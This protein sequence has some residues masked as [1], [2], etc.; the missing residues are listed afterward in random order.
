[1]ARSDLTGFMMG[2]PAFPEAPVPTWEQFCADY[3][4]YFFDGSRPHS[5]RSFII[6]VAAGDRASS[7]PDPHQRLHPGVGHISYS[8]LDELAGP[9]AELDIWM[10]DSSCCGRGWGTAAVIALSEHLETT[11]NV[12]ELMLRPSARNLRAIHAYENAGFTRLSLSRAE[13]DIRYG[14]GEYHDTV[15]LRRTAERTRGSV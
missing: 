7:E 12:R 15:I 2:P 9:A 13:Q 10:R 3:L 6:E 5:G 4:P 14:P 1:M 8:R 11:F